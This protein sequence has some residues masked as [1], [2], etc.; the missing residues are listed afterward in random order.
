VD[1]LNQNESKGAQRDG[2]RLTHSLVTSFA[3]AAITGLILFFLV[4]QGDFSAAR[5]AITILIVIVGAA[6][7]FLILWKGR[8]NSLRMV[9]FVWMNGLIFTIAFSL[10][11]EMH[12]GSI[13]LTHQI[14]SQTGAPICPITIPFVAVPYFTEGKM[15][16]PSPVTSLF[17]ILF[18]WLGLVL[19]LGRGWC[20]WICFFGWMDQ[21]FA[22][23]LKKPII[24]LEHQPKWAKLFPYAFMLFLILVSAVFLTPVFCAYMCPLRII[25]DPPGVTTTFQWITALIFVTGGLTFLVVG[26]LLT[27]KRLFCSFICPLMPA[28]AVVGIIN[29]FKVKVDKSL[30]KDCGLCVKNCELFAITKESLAKGGTTIEC[31]KCGKCMDKCPTGAIVY[32][33]MF[34]GQGMRSWF[35]PLAVIFNMLLVSGFIWMIVRYLL[36]GEMGSFQ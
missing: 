21:F 3:A 32:R 10:E 5:L 15:I 20:G 29:P 25:Y 1:E 24:S 26:P 22:S 14:L 9:A 30:C 34:T 27:K 23:L 12:R 35:I 6:L 28:N 13:L 31:A 2:G 17:A 7:T 36:T 19:I 33:L 18:M 4:G 16:F 8:V 11:H